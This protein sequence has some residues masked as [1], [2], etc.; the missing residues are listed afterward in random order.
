MEDKSDKIMNDIIWDA[1]KKLDLTVDTYQK[2]MNYLMS[3]KITWNKSNEKGIVAACVYI[4]AN[5]MREIRSQRIVG[6]AFGVSEVTVR[7]HYKRIEK[8]IGG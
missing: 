2:A 6:N 5:L 3:G 7:N 4:A 8:L 1:C